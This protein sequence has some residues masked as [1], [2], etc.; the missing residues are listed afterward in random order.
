M[1]GDAVY[2]NIPGTFRK[3]LE[4]PN[5]HGCKLAS[6]QNADRTSEA[7]IKS[8]YTAASHSNNT[9]VLLIKEVTNVP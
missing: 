9:C 5:K 4:L 7:G 6:S 8:A 3:H 1:S 2:T